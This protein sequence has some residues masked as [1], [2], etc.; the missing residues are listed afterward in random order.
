MF[1]RYLISKT[2]PHSSLK[3]AVLSVKNSDEDDGEVPSDDRAKSGA[4]ERRGGRGCHRRVARLH[5]L[6]VQ[7]KFP[8][9]IL[10]LSAGIIAPS[11]SIWA[12]QKLTWNPG[13]LERARA[14]LSAT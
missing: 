2:G 10:T 9:A 8:M 7:R 11:G 12:R 5:H 14:P 4:R 1:V 3:C 13:A 6:F